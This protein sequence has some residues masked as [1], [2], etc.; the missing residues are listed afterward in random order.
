MLGK[1]ETTASAEELFLPFSKSGKIYTRK[2]VSGNFRHMVIEKNKESTANAKKTAKPKSI[3]ADFL[4]S[5]ELMLLSKYTPASVIVDEHMDIVHINGA[6]GP[7]LE[8]PQG[9]PTYNLLKMA[10]QGLSF[11]LRTAFFKT[12]ETG[13]GVTK[14]GISIK[15]NG[16][17]TDVTIE[18]VPIPDSVQPHFLV[19][20]YNTPYLEKEI[21]FSNLSI[22]DIHN[23]ANLKRIKQLENELALLHKDVQA[24]TEDQEASNEEL[25]SANEELL[26]G[27]EEL[28]SLNEELETSKE[29]LQSS[30]EELIIINQELIN[31]QE[32]VNI[33]RDYT[34]AIVA[35]LREPIVVLDT[36]LRIKNINRS[37]VKKFH[38]TKL[39]AEGK[40]IYEIQNHLFD[41]SVMRT[42]LE[43]VLTQQM[44]LDD[45]EITIN[46]LPFGESTMLLNARQVTTEK[47]NELLILLAIED[48]TERKEIEKRLRTFSEDLEIKVG[49]RTADL[50]KTNADLKVAMK[51]TMQANTKLQQFA[52]V[53]SHDLQEPLR[54][55]LMFTS[56]LEEFHNKLPADAVVL[57]EKV[58]SSSDRMKTLIHDLLEYSYLNNDESM[59]VPIDLNIILSNVISDFELSIEQNNATVNICVL[60]KITAIPL[61]MNQLFYNLISNALKFCC[62]DERIPIIDISVRSMSISEI[63]KYPALN[64]LMPYCE[65]IFKDNGIG[66][67]QHYEKQ[68]FTIFQ[69]LHSND[70]YVGTGIGLAISKKIIEN[71]KGE[72]FAKAKPNKGAEFHIILPLDLA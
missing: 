52:Y 9:K 21:A 56:R 6:I 13:E 11:E 24:I 64:H 28:Q 29:E 16:K 10:R 51:E 40:L 36:E 7:F 63:E 14:A 72:I 8:S 17:D 20:F 32:L 22:E 54:K 70:N 66:F 42:L 35:T 47:S 61:Q 69:R 46:L 39:E 53:A 30:N 34:E 4:D 37:F 2:E 1:S 58:S 57:L 62:P 23:D 50:V 48:I 59:F 49:E 27:S 12:K 38:I 5:A 19:L 33:S 31:K 15:I 65:I 67:E 45:Y 41:N 26:S 25:Q 71:H 3:K 44:Q 60:P 55:I 43:E 68:I 18:V